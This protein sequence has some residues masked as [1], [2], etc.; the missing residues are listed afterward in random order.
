MKGVLLGLLLLLPSFARADEEESGGITWHGL[1]DLRAHAADRHVSWLRGGTNRLRYGGR[2]V[3]RDGTG[4][5][6]MLGVSVAQA[7]LVL[8]S[9]VLPWAKVH[10]QSNFSMDAPSQTAKIGIIEAYGDVEHAF[11]DEV[12]RLRLGGFIPPLSWEH[13]DKA[14]ST[15]YTLTPSAIGSW[16][17]EEV[18]TLGAELVWQHP[19]GEHHSGKLTGGLFSGGDQIGHL[20]WFRG[21]AMHDF[22]GDLTVDYPIQ[23]RRIRP[24]EEQDARQGYYGRGDVRLW[25]GLFTAGGGYWTNNADINIGAA[26]ASQLDTQ[27]F[28]TTVGHYGGKLEYKRLTLLGQFMKVTVSSFGRPARDW[29]AAYGLASYAGKWIRLSYRYDRFW[30]LGWDNGHAHTGYAGWRIS[31]KQELGLEYVYAYAR[32]SQQLRP[33][34]E[35]TRQVQFNYRLRY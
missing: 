18:R 3:D 25:D 8:E 9:D 24:L 32:P 14:W 7:S 4:D 5:K 12:F 23:G 17:G 27:P 6:H 20:M 29:P 35:A 34:A 26:N 2:D 21:W 22:V 10:V 15:R 13:P 16:V 19:V 33:A 31:V 11:G 28:R 30:C 1:L